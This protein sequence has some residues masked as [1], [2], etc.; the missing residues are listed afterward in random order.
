MGETCY[1]RVFDG[2]TWIF[3]NWEIDLSG[4]ENALSAAGYSVLLRIQEP[5]P[6]SVPKA[7]RSTKFNWDLQLY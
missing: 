1:T 6:R 7:E 4:E 2:N 3:P 5:F